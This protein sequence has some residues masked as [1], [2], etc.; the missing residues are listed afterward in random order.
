M[1]NEICTRKV[2]ILIKPDALQALVDYS[3]PMIVAKSLLGKRRR[4]SLPKN[5]IFGNSALVRAK[6]HNET[7]GWFLPAGSFKVL[8]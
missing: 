5:K 1:S 4:A 2:R 7:T 8:R 6:F 3:V